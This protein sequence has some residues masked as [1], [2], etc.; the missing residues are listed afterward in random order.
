[1]QFTQIGGKRSTIQNISFGVPQGSVLRHLLF[2]ICINDIDFATTRTGTILCADD[3]VIY[4]KQ[5]LKTA[6]DDHQKALETSAIRLKKN[7]RTLNADKPKTV[8]FYKKKK[9]LHLNNLKIDNKE[10]QCCSI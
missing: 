10:I 8:R 9:P 4:T 1:M 6:S 2:F 7:R 5:D 3:T